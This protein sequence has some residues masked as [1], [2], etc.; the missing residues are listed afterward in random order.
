MGRKVAV[1]LVAVFAVAASVF[2]ERAESPLIR[3]VRS[4]DVNAVRTLLKQHADANAAEL[5]GTT[6]LHWAAHN[7]NLAILDLLLSAH[8]NVA[9]ATRYGAVPLTLACMTGNAA[10]IDRL[11]QAGADPNSVLPDGETALMTASRTG[12]VD[13]IKT[14]VA[15]GA[16]V[17]A[18][19]KSRGQTALMWAASDG[20][21]DVVKALVEAGADVHAHSNPPPPPR[22]RGPSEIADGVVGPLRGNNNGTTAALTPLLFAAR[23][24]YIDVVRFL[25]DSRADINEKASDGTD[26]LLFATMNAH[27]ELGKFLLDRGA[28]PN[29]NGRGFTALH[30]LTVTRR[31]NEGHLPH[32]VPTGRLDSMAFAEA[33]LAH[34]ADVNA[35][36]TVPSMGDGYRNRL[37]RTGATP[38]LL[39]A[40]G[41]DP[42]M[43]RFLLKAGADPK[44]T[45]VENTN[46]LML[47]AGVALY[48]PNEDA[49]T[50]EEGLE[51]TK[52]A[53]ETG[54]DINAADDNGETALH[55]AAYKGFN[56]VVQYL[57]DKGAQLDVWNNQGWTPLTIASGVMYTNFIKSQRQTE[58]LLRKL[59]VDRKLPVPDEGVDVTAAG[60][61]KQV[62]ADRNVAPA[63]KRPGGGDT[64]R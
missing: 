30:Q 54:L 7:G 37:N 40:K 61:T 5:D 50:E 42:I 57:V 19:E 10:A 23:S 28:N 21:L 14:L 2:A 32:P 48:N 27:W 17:D 25:L 8:A 38:F 49:G 15:H 36:M 20:N 63:S 55:G 13:A 22:R 33:L 44:L 29:A 45:N 52:V 31:L 24:G 9:A 51:A 12:K 18:R 60:Y 34:G 56:S 43:M 3:A 11:L 46:A 64:Q 4:S 35:R 58:I 47:A 41:D 1:G 16:K 59:M 26:A 39:A 53:L 6:A 62:P